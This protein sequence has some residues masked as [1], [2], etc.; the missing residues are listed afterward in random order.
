MVQSPIWVSQSLFILLIRHVPKCFANF[1]TFKSMNAASAGYS[2]DRAGWDNA[3]KK[4]IRSPSPSKYYY[5]IGNV[6]KYYASWAQ[7]ERLGNVR[8]EEQHIAKSWAIKRLHWIHSPTASSPLLL[9]R[10]LHGLEF[11]PFAGL[12]AIS[13]DLPFW[14]KHMP[15]ATC[16]VHKCGQLDGFCLC[17]FRLMEAM[18][19]KKTWPESSEDFYQLEQKVNGPRCTSAS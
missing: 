16:M 4:K 17:L 19:G 8:W 1:I 9:Q 13:F 3:L 18:L 15:S 6:Q 5:P 2:Y 12:T 11:P 10:L 7:L 14:R